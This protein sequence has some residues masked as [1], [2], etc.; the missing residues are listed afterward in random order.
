MHVQNM[1]KLVNGPG[2]SASLWCVHRDSR[3]DVFRY[4]NIDSNPC[5]PLS[6][7]HS[8]CF[9]SFFLSSSH[10]SDIWGDTG[11]ADAQRIAPAEACKEIQAW[12]FVEW[13]RSWSQTQSRDAACSSTEVWR[14]CHLPKPC[15]WQERWWQSVADTR[16]E[17]S[18]DHGFAS[19]CL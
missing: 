13:V 16:L 7:S 5:F 3:F 12:C 10:C 15:L 19:V 11:M 2:A 8:F 17:T 9:P 1:C 14:P 4:I 6:L 18:R